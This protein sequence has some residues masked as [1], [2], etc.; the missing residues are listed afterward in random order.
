MKALK[1]RCDCYADFSHN[2]E[3]LLKIKLEFRKAI[4]LDDYLRKCVTYE[5]TYEFLEVPGFYV[6]KGLAVQY[7]SGTYNS[8]ASR[9]LKDEVLEG[10]KINFILHTNS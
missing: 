9:L 6:L 10:R 3:D 8:S 5:T 7:L 1:S 2:Q 4:K